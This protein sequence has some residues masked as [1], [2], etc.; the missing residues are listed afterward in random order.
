M[1]PWLA[2]LELNTNQDSLE[3]KDLTPS[4]TVC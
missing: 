2:G 4:I 3:L 1:L